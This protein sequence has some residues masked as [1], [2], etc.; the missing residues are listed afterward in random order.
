MHGNFFLLLN[1]QN[2][3]GPQIR[4]LAVAIEDGLMVNEPSTFQGEG[5]MVCRPMNP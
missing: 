2:P 1:V 4:V 5:P 3:R